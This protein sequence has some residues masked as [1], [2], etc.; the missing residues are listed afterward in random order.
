MGEVKRQCRTLRTSAEYNTGVRV[1][2]DSPS[3]SWLEAAS[4]ER[5]GKWRKTVRFEQEAPNASLPMICCSGTSCV[6]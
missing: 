6:W 2:D 1:A 4:Q 3:L 5:S